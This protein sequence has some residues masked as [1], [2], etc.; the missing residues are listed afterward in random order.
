[1]GGSGLLRCVFRIESE[2]Y[3]GFEL[4]ITVGRPE[5]GG[6]KDFIGEKARGFGVRDCA[7]GWLA[8]CGGLGVNGRDVNKRLNGLEGFVEDVA[9]FMQLFSV[10][11]EVLVEEL[12][13]VGG[14]G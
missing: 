9:G 8:G 14:L 6:G 4:I 12:G 2:F 5:F 7:D 13:A 11:F 1:M 10:G 3:S